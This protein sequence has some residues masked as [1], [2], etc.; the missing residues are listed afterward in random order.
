[1][2]PLTPCCQIRGVLI[3]PQGVPGWGLIAVERRQN[4]TH[5]DKHEGMKRLGL[6]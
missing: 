4:Q 1:M 6:P 2:V 3:P 5:L